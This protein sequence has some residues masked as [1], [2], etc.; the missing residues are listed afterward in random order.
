M[1]LN[2]TGVDDAL[3]AL[4]AVLAPPEP[5]PPTTTPP[6]ADAPPEKKQ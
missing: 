4:D 6:A 3:K 5:A 1:K 2:A